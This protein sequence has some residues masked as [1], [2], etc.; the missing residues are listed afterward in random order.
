MSRLR[1]PCL[2]CGRV[3]D[4]SSRCP[5]CFEKV[6]AVV[7]KARANR[8]RNREHYSGDYRRRA[9]LV[10]ATA[11]ECW[12]CHEGARVDDPWQADHVI[13]G[14]PDSILAAAHR[15]CNITRSNRIIAERKRAGQ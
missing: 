10:R 5:S 11:V 3:T 1:K 7:E 12:I 15:S 13:P 4:G 2:D 6:R 14:D 9:A 8:P